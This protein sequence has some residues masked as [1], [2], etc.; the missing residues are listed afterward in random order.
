MH[1]PQ[2]FIVNNAT[3]TTWRLKL[4][5]NKNKYRCKFF[6]Q[7]RVYGFWVMNSFNKTLRFETKS[8]QQYKKMDKNL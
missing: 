6:N 3:S 5:A 8:K 4:T 2:R 7:S 1:V